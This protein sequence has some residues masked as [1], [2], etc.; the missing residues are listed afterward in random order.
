MEVA[1]AVVGVSTGDVARGVGVVDEDA[2][3]VAR[4]GVT[5]HLRMTVA[6]LLQ[7]PNGKI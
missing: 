3:S 4:V 7:K 6:H 5:F 1:P 2:G